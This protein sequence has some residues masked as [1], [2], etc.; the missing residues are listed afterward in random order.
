VSYAPRLQEY[1]LNISD[2]FCTLTSLARAF[3]NVITQGTQI[4]V[5]HRLTW[6]DTLKL[7]HNSWL[8][9]VAKPCWCQTTMVKSRQ[10]GKG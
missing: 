2:L 3:I 9:E 6:H 10:E 8:W 5:K 4:P 1:A 7:S